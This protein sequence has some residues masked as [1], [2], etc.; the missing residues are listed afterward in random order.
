MGSMEAARRAGMKPAAVAQ[1]A[2][3]DCCSGEGERI[4]AAHAVELAGH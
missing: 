1:R 4:V 3:D 2:K